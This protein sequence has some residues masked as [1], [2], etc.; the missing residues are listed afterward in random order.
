MST[1]QK[2]ESAA[3]ARGDRK[4]N[5][6]SGATRDPELNGFVEGDTF[7][8]PANFDG[9]VYEMNIG[10]GTAQY[11][12]V[13]VGTEK[14]PDYKQF[15]PSTFWKSRAICTETGELTGKR[16]KTEGNATAEFLKHGSVH[17]GMMALATKTLKITKIDSHKTRSFNDPKRVV[18]AQ[19]FTIDIVA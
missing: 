15:F 8:L 11:I 16:A 9:Q 2:L 14:E 13:N 3:K 1:F 17:E 12:L 10:T 6:F 4:L 18:D 5:S 19:F 7:T